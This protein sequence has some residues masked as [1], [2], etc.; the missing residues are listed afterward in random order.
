MVVGDSTALT[1]GIDLGFAAGRHHATIVDKGLLGCGVVEVSE[2]SRQGRSQPARVAAPCNPAS[3]VRERWPALWRTWLARYHPS[4]VA[5][6]AG[7]GEV[8]N[9]LWHGAWTNIMHRAFARYVRRQLELA[10]TVASSAGA[11]VDLLT[12]PCYSTGTEPGTGVV[13][14]NSP[15]RLAIYNDLLNDVAIAD[16]SRTTLVNL[17][18]AVCPRG[19]YRETIGEVTIRAPDGV[20]FPFFSMS[21]PNTADPDALAQVRRFGSWLGRT[22]WPELLAPGPARPRGASG[23][24]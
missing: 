20:H 5:V 15:R 16:A 7:R 10:V 21:D 18:A 1:L 17:D 12:A 4:V 8:S 14:A 19:H 3:P 11:H 24:A 22:L 23:H 6:L 2:V 9:V 13:T